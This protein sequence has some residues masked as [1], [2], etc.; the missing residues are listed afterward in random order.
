MKIVIDETYSIESDRYN[1]KLIEI[2]SKETEEENEEETEVSES[3][4]RKIV[5]GYFSTFKGVLRLLKEEMIKKIETEKFEK[6]SGEL[7]KINSSL[8]EIEK[9]IEKMPDLKPVKP[10]KEEG[11]N[12]E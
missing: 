9:T 12:D 2:R 3:G 6:I 11:D 7:E 10:E 5:L 4:E 1:Y 8:K